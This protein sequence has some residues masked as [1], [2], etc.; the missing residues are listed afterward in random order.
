[1]ADRVYR[2]TFATAAAFW[3]RMMPFYRGAE[4]TAAQETDQ[5]WSI[6]FFI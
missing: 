2:N 1:M 6:A 4:W 5:R 3:N